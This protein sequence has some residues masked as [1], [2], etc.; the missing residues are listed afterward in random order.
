MAGCPFLSPRPSQ[1]AGTL[2]IK[3][4]KV[5]QVM[6]DGQS[7]PESALPRD[8]CIGSWNF[9]TQSYY[10]VSEWL[11]FCLVFCLNDTKIIKQPSGSV[12]SLGFVRLQDSLAAAFLCGQE[13]LLGSHCPGWLPFHCY[14]IL[15][16]SNSPKLTGT[17]RQ[18]LPF[19]LPSLLLSFLF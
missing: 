2:I 19:I 13:G 16:I 3:K 12:S 17:C 18:F 9:V 10:H 5:R 4:A 1:A 8:L 6:S 7:Y 15:F 14:I 11:D